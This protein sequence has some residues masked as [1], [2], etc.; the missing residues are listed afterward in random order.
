[1]TTAAPP[2]T[3][4]DPTRDELRALLLSGQFLTVQ[5]LFDQRHAAHAAGALDEHHLHRTYRLASNYREELTPALRTWVA[6]VP[7]SAPAQVALGQ[8]LLGQGLKLRTMRL[9][10]DIPEAH[11]DA[12]A[13][14]WG[15]AA[16]QFAHA[17][18]LD[19]PAT[20]A[21]TGLIAPPGTPI[22]AD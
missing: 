19:P 12:M 6:E 21:H 11:R 20:L 10:R 7:D 18:T 5:R 2:R 17:L 4:P 22:S 14:A 15:A 1:M 8:H 16:H 9:G 3:L 13:G